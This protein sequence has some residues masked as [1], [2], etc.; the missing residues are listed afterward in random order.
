MEF[1]KNLKLWHKV[2]VVILALLLLKACTST[3]ATTKPVT[4]VQS[5][6]ITTNT[7]ASVDGTPNKP[8][9]FKMEQKYGGLV[10]RFECNNP[11]SP[12]SGLRMTYRD[13]SG[14]I[15]DR[16]DYRVYIAFSGRGMTPAAKD[17][18][19]F[20][21]LIAKNGGNLDTILTQTGTF[22]INQIK[23]NGDHDIH[24]AISTSSEDASFNIVKT[25]PSN[26]F[27]LAINEILRNNPCSLYS[28]NK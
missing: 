23:T 7:N 17:W 19:E 11:N 5:E 1:W 21:R 3:K 6:V 28:E 20:D 27:V 25:F 8:S 13:K 15:T 18:A 10:V 26:Y 22:T 16:G 12:K 14:N 9:A 2:V 24:F 4:T